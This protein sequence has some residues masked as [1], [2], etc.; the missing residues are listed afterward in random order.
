VMLRALVVPSFE[1]AG[2]C[3]DL[4]D[5]GARDLEQ[6]FHGRRV[7]HFGA[8]ILPLRVMPPVFE[9]IDLG[10]NQAQPATGSPGREPFGHSET[11]PMQARFNQVVQVELHVSNPKPPMFQLKLHIIS[12]VACT[13]VTARNSEQLGAFGIHTSPRPLFPKFSLVSLPSAHGGTRQGA[14]KPKVIRGESSPSSMAI[15]VEGGIIESRPYSLSVASICTQLRPSRIVTVEIS[16]VSAEGDS[17]SAEKRSMEN[18]DRTLKELTTPDVVYQ[19]WCI[20]CP[21]LEPIQSY[22]LQFSLIQL[23]PNFHGL[24]GEDPHKHLKEFHVV[25]STMRP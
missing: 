22:E 7:S 14:K 15:I 21:P 24:A 11:Q 10:S 19:P 5:I 8:N 4:C 2:S 9:R 6:W 1:E 3:S 23:L 18:N 16:S 17:A 25:C 13:Q 12:W 20:Q